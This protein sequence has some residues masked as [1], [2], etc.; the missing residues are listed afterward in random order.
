MHTSPHRVR[1]LGICSSR[2]TRLARSHTGARRAIVG[3]HA[4][5]ALIH[6]A[7][8]ARAS[9]LRGA[10]NAQHASLWHFARAH[11]RTHINVNFATFA[12]IDVVSGQACIDTSHCARTFMSIQTRTDIKHVRISTLR[13]RHLLMAKLCRDVRRQ[14]MRNYDT[15][16]HVSTHTSPHNTTHQ[17][18]VVLKALHKHRQR[19]LA[20]LATQRETS[21]IAHAQHARVPIFEQR[22]VGETSV[23]SQCR[24]NNNT[25]SHA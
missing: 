15:R 19:P 1:R 6:V 16:A 5:G 12:R 22:Q 25:Q 10:H 18:R 21:I 2:V 14:L 9:A 17:R 23:L 4:L 3:R 13:V 24:A 20:R 8:T 7:E 11:T